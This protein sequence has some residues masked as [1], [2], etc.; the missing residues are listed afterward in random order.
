MNKNTSNNMMEREFDILQSL[1]QIE[2]PAHLYKTILTQTSAKAFS[3]SKKW[4]AG[5]AA[6]MLL[7][8]CAELMIILSS[9]QT[10]DVEIIETLV[11]KQN[12]QLYE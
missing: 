4:L 9:N 7:V 8:V 10:E 5:A 12:H 2:P 3:V 6:I 11:Q 1:E